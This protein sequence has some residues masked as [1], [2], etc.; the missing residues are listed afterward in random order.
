MKKSPNDLYII[1][2]YQRH[3][4]FRMSKTPKINGPRAQFNFVYLAVDQIYKETP[5]HLELELFPFL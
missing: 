2:Y 5:I 1:I 3:C 4:K